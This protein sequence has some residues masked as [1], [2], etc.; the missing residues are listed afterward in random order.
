M[1]VSTQEEIDAAFEKFKTLIEPEVYS[2]PLAVPFIFLG[3]SFS[4]F[5]LEE[6]WSSGQ[7][8]SKGRGPALK[9]SAQI[10][11]DAD[12]DEVKG[13]NVSGSRYKSPKPIGREGKA[14]DVIAYNPYD[15]LE[16]VDDEDE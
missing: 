12:D 2:A 16:G 13:L 10:A 1:R 9:K 3:S 14:P 6:G 11:D 15:M 5:S 8:R 7:G 4:R